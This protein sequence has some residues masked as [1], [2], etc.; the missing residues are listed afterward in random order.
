MVV[1]PE[2]RPRERAFLEVGFFGLAVLCALAAGVLIVIPLMM[3]LFSGAFVLWDY[4]L[5]VMALAFA[6]GFWGLSLL[7]RGEMLSKDRWADLR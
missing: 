2:S 4:G 7:S 1:D 3:A 6:A 5:G